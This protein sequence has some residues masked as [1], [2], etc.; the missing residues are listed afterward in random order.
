MVQIQLGFLQ[1][2]DVLNDI[3]LLAVKNDMMAHQEIHGPADRRQEKI[4]F[5]SR[6]HIPVPLPHRI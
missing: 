2:V 5:D 6:P 1:E 3:G 4:G